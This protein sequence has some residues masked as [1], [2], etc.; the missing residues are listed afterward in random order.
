MTENDIAL[1]KP[2]LIKRWIKRIVLGIIILI[3]FFIA[4]FTTLRLYLKWTH[5]YTFGKVIQV[6][7]DE[8]II[9]SPSGKITTVNIKSSTHI[10][11]GNQVKKLAEIKIGDDAIVIG[12]VSDH[13]E[14]E[15]KLV[16]LVQP[17]SNNE[18]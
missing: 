17:R 7:K 5:Q 14:I 18:K 3:L 8:I 16:R 15:A 4:A 6:G 13:Q 1:P 2:R 9:D 12:K 10:R 11:R